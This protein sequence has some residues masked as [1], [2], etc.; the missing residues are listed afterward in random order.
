MPDNFYVRTEES[1]LPAFDPRTYR[2]VVDGLVSRPLAFTYRHLLWLPSSRQRCNFLCIEGWGVDDVPWEGVKLGTLM[3]LARPLEEA[4]F[5]TFH[6]LGGVY[7]ESLSLEQA[8]LPNALLAYRMYGCPL[9]PERGSPLRLVFPRMLGYKGAKWVTRV[10]F[11]SERD[12]GYWERFGANVNP[13][14]ED[15]QPC[16]NGGPGSAPWCGPRALQDRTGRRVTATPTP[17]TLQP[18]AEP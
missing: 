3:R 13:W 8:E 4:R 6:C 15:E 9:P 10:E 12:L 14:V 7:Q 1:P 5:V 17:A 11:R 18:G 16:S 2:L